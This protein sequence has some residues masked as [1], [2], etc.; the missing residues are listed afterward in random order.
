MIAAKIR[1]LLS[2]REFVSVG[3]CDLQH[4]PNVAPKFILKM[5]GSFLYLVDYVLGATFNNIKANPRVS[6][7]IMDTE[8]LIG[9]Q[10]NGPVE[11]L[12]G[13]DEYDKIQKELLQRKIDLSTKRIIE[14]VV[15]GKVHDGFEVGMP[16]KSVVL[17]IIIEE[18]VEIGHSGQLKRQKI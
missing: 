12:C 13:G 8:A 17:K 10:I 11:I 5:D 3:T 15:H 1:D 4:Q 14:G 2:S 18:V 16:E 7:S 6:V 9:Y